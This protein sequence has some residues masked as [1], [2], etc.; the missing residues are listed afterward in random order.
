MSHLQDLCHALKAHACVDV[1]GG[2]GSEGA[3]WGP[4]TLHEH[5]VIE[6]DEPVECQVVR[7]SGNDVRV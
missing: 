1:A 2:Q 3:I 5:E 4:V 7:M 6:L